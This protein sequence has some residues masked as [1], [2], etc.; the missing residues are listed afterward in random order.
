MSDKVEQQP[1]PVTMPEELKNWQPYCPEMLSPEVYQVQMRAH[2][3]GIS[4]L[5]NSNAIQSIIRQLADLTKKVCELE[6]ELDAVIKRVDG[7]FQIIS[8]NNKNIHTMKARIEALENPHS[9][10]PNW[11]DNE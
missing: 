1:E 3:Q 9:A 11:G 6:K 4:I 10:K 5:Q 8:G 7:Y 2:P